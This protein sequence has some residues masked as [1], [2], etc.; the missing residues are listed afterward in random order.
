MQIK[1]FSKDAA[2]LHIWGSAF[3]QGTLDQLEALTRMPYI[4][5]HVAAMPDAHVGIGATIG[6]VFATRN[7]VVPSAVGVDIGCGMRAVR[8]S[9]P[10]EAGTQHLLQRFVDL[11]YSRIPLGFESHSNS[12]DWNGLK[13]FPLA[14][15]ELRKKA[16]MQLGTLGGGNHFVEVQSDGQCLWLMIHTGSRHI[17]LQ[18]AERSIREAKK[19][20]THYK[21]GLPPDLSCLPLDSSEGQEYMEAM[22]WALDYARENRRQLMEELLDIFREAIAPSFDELEDIEI[23]HNFAAFEE[24]FSKRVLVHRK[25]ATRAYTGEYGIIPGSMG[26]VSYITRGKG[27]PDSFMSSSHGAGRAMGRREAQKRF[28]MDDFKRSMKGVVANLRKNMIDEIPLAYKNIDEVMK[29]QEDL[30][31]IVYMLPPLASVKG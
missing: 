17:G 19:Y 23:N 30:V 2:P 27:N 10:A 20:N 15:K 29:A 25:G 22:N 31:E 8:T 4:F 12:R 16:A 9:L 14:D 3:D 28:G 7:A 6:S 11:V 21:M 18:I 13:H 1:Q 26:A 5:D 24:H